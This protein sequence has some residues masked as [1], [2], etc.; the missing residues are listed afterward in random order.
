MQK[1]QLYIQG[2]RIDLFKDETV[3]LTQTIQN[4]KDIS[5][6]FTE[7]SQTFSLP[8][9]P[10]N[11]KLFKHYY[12]FHIDGGFDARN[13][14]SASLEL[15]TIPF[16]DGFIK[17]E[18]VDLKNN[19][20]HTYRVTFFGN[21]INLSDVLGDDQLSTLGALA[22]QNQD[23][24][25]DTIRS[26]LTT[27]AV[28]DNI[29]APL[30]THTQRLF[31]DS[32]NAAAAQGNLHYQNA[33]NIN[34]VLWSDLKFA[35][36]LDFI[37][38][39]IQAQ[40]NYGLTFSSNF[41]NNSS[42]SAFNNLYMWLHRK[43]G[44]VEATTQLVE[45]FVAMQ[46]LS[47]I[48]GSLSPD[49]TFTPNGF[50]TL[51]TLSSS[52]F[53]SETR[54]I[55][56]P[57]GTN[58]YSI[59]VFRNGA[60]IST[61]SEVTGNQQMFD[62]FATRLGAGTYSIELASTAGITFAAGGIKWQIS[63]TQAGA[64]Q[65]GG[66]GTQIMANSGNVDTSSTVEF[67][68]PQQIPEMT[69]I[70]FLTAIFKMFNLTAFV[71]NSGVIVVR[72]LDSYYATGN[73]TPINIDSYLDV[74]KSSVN[75]ALPFKEIIYRFKGTG[76]FLAKQY[77]QLNNS[78]WGTLKY[79][80]DNETFDGSTNT[81]KVEIPFEHIMNERLFDADNN[82]ATTV[83]YGY[84]VDDNQEPYYGLPLVFYAIRQLNGTPI[85]LKKETN[86]NFEINDYI[87]PSNSKTLAAS[88]ST[89]NINFQAEVN[90]YSPSDNFTGTLF[91]NYYFT[92]I[93]EVF[94][95]RKRLTKVTAYLPLKIYHNLQLNDLMQMNQQNYKINSI[96]TNLT[97][98]KSEI[99]LLNVTI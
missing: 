89:T 46:D 69:I 11:N 13:K 83:Q 28:G 84:F 79:T 97:N 42:N 23:Y 65:G 20:A 40:A 68:I 66:G 55:L 90:E 38:D 41:F 22:L 54:L 25:Y 82:T 59:R 86:E 92:Y 37:I 96:T 49:V 85:S 99:E 7:F 18:G 74:T 93:S 31:Y 91:Q 30:I 67:I 95:T 43:K 52:E 15:N 16:K 45:N 29:I 76:T 10:T 6:I 71:D 35:V 19:V 50:L 80:L 8:A 2:V 64:G 81:Y 51:A 1:L 60:L 62:T 14:V 5:K 17:L 73:S 12:N 56:A 77:A 27:A 3:S 57:V 47:L 53:Y 4:V 61:L 26:K 63:I 36:K 58:P 24:D 9:S 70:D 94:N 39:A 21:T 88:A 33:T 75:V 44:S 98:G 34:G 32:D 87:I 78:E 72:T 48:S